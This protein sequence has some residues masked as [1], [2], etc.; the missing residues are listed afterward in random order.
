MRSIINIS[1]PPATAKE[2]KNIVKQQG[3]AS[4]SEF[5]RHLMRLWKTKQL[6]EELL[7]DRA[8]FEAGKGRKLKSLADIK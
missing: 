3:F 2:I 8:A 4:T 1:V 5:I 6:S 7:Q